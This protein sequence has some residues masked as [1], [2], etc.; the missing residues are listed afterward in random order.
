MYVCMNVC[1]YVC[2]YVCAHS[3]SE[4]GP[5]GLDAPISP[6]RECE[7]HLRG[8][9]AAHQSHHPPRASLPGR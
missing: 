8:R 3:L 1:M 7:R 5:H 9:F 2:M 4:D 6:T